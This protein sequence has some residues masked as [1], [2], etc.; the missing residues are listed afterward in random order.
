MKPIFRR[1]TGIETEYAV[2]AKPLDGDP[3]PTRIEVYNRI[4]S[5]IA[6]QM[7]AVR[8]HHLKDGAFL[9]TG[10]AVWLE[11]ESALAATGNLIEGSSPECRSPRELLAHQRAQDKVFEKASRTP[12][13]DV[14]F[15]VLKNCRDAAG[16]FYGTHENYDAEFATG[17]R[18]LLWRIGLVATL[19]L[20]LFAWLST[21]I[22]LLG[23]LAYEFLFARLVLTALGLESR[24]TWLTRLLIGVDRAQGRDFPAPSP[25]WFERVVIAMIFVTQTPLA[26]GLAGLLAICGFHRVRNQ[27]LPFLITRPMIS[28]AGWIDAGGEFGL[29]ERGPA[30]THVWGFNGFWKERTIFVFGN[31][32]KRLGSEVMFAPYELVDMFRGRQRLQIG[33]G[34]SNQCETAEYLK[35]ATTSLVLDCIEAGMLPAPPRI[36]HPLKA[37]RL[38]CSDTSCAAPISTRSGSCTPIEIQRFYL[39]A[40][41]RFVDGHSNPPAEAHAV[42]RLWEQ[43]L[44]A[45]ESRPTTLVGKIDWLTK[46]HLLE[47]AGKDARPETRKKIDLKYHEL[48]PGGYFQMLA[49]SGLVERILNDDEIDRA[50]RLPPVDTPATQRGMLIREFANGSEPLWVNWRWVR[51]GTRRRA[52]WIPLIDRET[53][54]ARLA[55]RKSPADRIS[56]ANGDDDDWAE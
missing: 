27:L 42:L 50:M 52:K 16:N 6:K 41:R 49:K 24:D 40:C 23:V 37:L 4:L 48:G 15:R 7:P 30:L 56:L 46:W 18:L 3:V 13:N 19:P 26:L 17:W 54:G 10:G 9:A 43:T 5:G 45:L 34:D 51:L 20:A 29:S 35:I 53:E 32:I 38:V 31:F 8:A 44:D 11:A 21:I 12:A 28:G 47:T 55:S 14:S 22:V 2:I 33:I 25:G 39:N 1:L 36:Y